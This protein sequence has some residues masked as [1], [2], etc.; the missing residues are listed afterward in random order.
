MSV[1]L[2]TFIKNRDLEL[3]L[4]NEVGD[5]QYIGKATT[6]K[7]SKSKTLLK[8]DTTSIFENIS[9]FTLA[10]LHSGRKLF[11]TFIIKPVQPEY[12]IKTIEL[13]Y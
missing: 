9:P 13:V 6:I 11:T 12:D 1:A 7:S 2:Q 4:F 3:T 5:V 10:S 8:F